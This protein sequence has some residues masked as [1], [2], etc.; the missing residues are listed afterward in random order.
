MTHL[1]KARSQ[2]RKYL[3]LIF[4][5]C[6]K[7]NDLGGKKVTK[8][9]HRK[10]KKPILSD[11]YAV[12]EDTLGLE[13]FLVVMNLPGQLSFRFDE[14]PVFLIAFLV[15]LPAASELKVGS[16]SSPWFRSFRTK[17]E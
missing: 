13:V 14:T 7:E 15:H 4:L 3:F 12:M 11:T 8:K 9:C 1:P 5:S 16:R 6:H 17:Y 2:Q 10:R